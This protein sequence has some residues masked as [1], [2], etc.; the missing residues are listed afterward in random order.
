MNIDTI[1]EVIHAEQARDLPACPVNLEDNVLRRVRLARGNPIAS[2][3]FD[4]LPG[5]LPGKA[6][7]FTALVLVLSLS[8]S[9]SVF[10]AARHAEAAAS[11]HLASNSLGFEVFKQT[12][13]LNFD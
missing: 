5:L 10:V 4:W 13:V 3:G 12:H 8:T 9:A 6:A 11:R 7:V 2:G 1:D